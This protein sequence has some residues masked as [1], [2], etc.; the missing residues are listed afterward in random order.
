MEIF[1]FLKD[2]VSWRWR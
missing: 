1:V 2:F